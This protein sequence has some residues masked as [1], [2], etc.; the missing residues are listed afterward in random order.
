MVIQIYTISSVVF[1]FFAT[2][3][4]LSLHFSEEPN[5]VDLS[6]FMTIGVGNVVTH[7]FPEC[8]VAMDNLARVLGSHIPSGKYVCNR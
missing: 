6:Q 8:S 1:F 4:Y 2:I 5:N 3:F 7:S